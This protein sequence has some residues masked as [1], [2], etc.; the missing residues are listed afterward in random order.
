MGR[1]QATSQG[2]VPTEPRLGGRYRPV[3]PKDRAPA[4][5]MEEQAM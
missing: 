3:Y 1:Y 5:E 2:H 4:A